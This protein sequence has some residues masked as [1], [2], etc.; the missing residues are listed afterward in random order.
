[1]ETGGGSGVGKVLLDNGD[2]RGMF[3]FLR[4][5][6]STC[7]LPCGISG[8]VVCVHAPDDCFYI[9]KN[10]GSSHQHTC[11]HVACCFATDR[12]NYQLR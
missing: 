7:E 10:A 8:M 11:T 4:E 3:W 12:I 6:E 2:L 5:R 1:M 9:R